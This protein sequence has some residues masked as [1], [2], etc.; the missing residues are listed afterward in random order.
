VGRRP[1]VR[2]P[3]S[4]VDKLKGLCL[5]SL[6]PKGNS[7]RV[8]ICGMAFWNV[9]LARIQGVWTRSDHSRMQNGPTAWTLFELSMFDLD[10]TPGPPLIG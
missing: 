6:L 5:K 10:P 4:V 3:W 9:G 7:K 8:S 2:R 1:C